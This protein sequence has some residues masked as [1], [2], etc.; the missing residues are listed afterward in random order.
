MAP[1]AARVAARE[2]RSPAAVAL[3][4]VTRRLAGVWCHVPSGPTGVLGLGTRAPCP[5]SVPSPLHRSQSGPPCEALPCRWGPRFL[6]SEPPRLNSRLR[7]REGQTRAAGGG[8]RL[9]RA[10]RGQ[11]AWGRPFKAWMLCHRLRSPE[12]L[13]DV[14]C[15]SSHQIHFSSCLREIGSGLGRVMCVCEDLGSLGGRPVQALPCRAL[16]SPGGYVSSDRQAEGRIRPGSSSLRAR[17]TA[18]PE[19]Q[20]PCWERHLGPLPV[21]AVHFVNSFSPGHTW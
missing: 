6:A 4:S 16:P 11:A 10:A 3:R 2:A 7:L 8:G 1:Q 5:L 12:F 14:T 19:P 17:R 13:G 20:L 21:T 18:S 15:A 9:Q